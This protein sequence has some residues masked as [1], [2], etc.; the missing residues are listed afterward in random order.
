MK[1]AEEMREQTMKDVDAKPSCARAEDLVAYLYGEANEAAR[2]SFEAHTRHCDSCE[3]EL[4]AFGQVRSSISEW[5]V[6]ALG[7]LSS[8]AATT[9]TPVSVAP[10]RAAKERERSALVALREFFS[11][12]PAWMRAASVATAVVFCALV[13]L[14]IAQYRQQPK[15]VV[16]EKIVPAQSS[17]KQSGLIAGEQSGQANETIDSAQDPVVSPAEVKIADASKDKPETRKFRRAPRQDVNGRQ[18]LAGNNRAPKLKIS[19]QESRELASDLRLTMASSEE[20]DLP[21]LSDL[22]EE[23]N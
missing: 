5:R 1:E 13:V 9:S 15:V 7:S 4:S 2:R 11:L 23:S 14:A 8:T 20:D 18:N 19:P 10:V 22:I 17:E 3:K 6:Q 21:R 12:S 16:V